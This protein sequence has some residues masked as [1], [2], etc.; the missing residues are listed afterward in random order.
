[1]FKT[2]IKYEILK[3]ELIQKFKKNIFVVFL[4]LLHVFILMS[5]YLTLNYKMYIF[6]FLFL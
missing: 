6:C 3:N 1:M 4:Y 5:L 2:F